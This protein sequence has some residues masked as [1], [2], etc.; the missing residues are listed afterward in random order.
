MEFGRNLFECLGNKAAIFFDFA[1]EGAAFVYGENLVN[2]L[3]VF[4]FSVS[5]YN[6]IITVLFCHNFY[7]WFQCHQ[8]SFTDFAG[9][10]FLQFHGFDIV[11]LRCNAMDH[12]ENG[13]HVADDNRY[14]IN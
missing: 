5:K 1:K 11:L 4:A 12:K 6:F 10:I 3:Q 7:V 9:D 13:L 14:N 8:C 2:V